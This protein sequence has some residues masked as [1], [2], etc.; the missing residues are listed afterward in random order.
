MNDEDENQELPLHLTL[1]ASEYSRIKTDTN[2]R[3]G[4]AGEPVAELTSPG[5]TMMSAGK[6]AHIHG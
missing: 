2:Q 5:W 3:I 4:K 1:R 6:E